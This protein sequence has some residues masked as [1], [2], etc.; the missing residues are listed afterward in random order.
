MSTIVSEQENFSLNDLSSGK[1]R[2]I[3]IPN[4]LQNSVCRTLSEK[5]L[6][7]LSETSNSLQSNIIGTSLSKHIYDK[8]GYF[9]NARKSNELIQNLFSETVS[10]LEK[11]F[12]TIELLSHKKILTATEDGNSYS[13]CAIRIHKNGDSVHLHRD[14]CNFEMPDYFV[15]KYKN[16]LSAILY[17]QTPQSGGELKIYDKIWSKDDESQRNPEFGYSFNVIEGV[18]Y[19][20]ISPVAG[21]LVL[22][23]PNYYHSIESISGTDDRISIGFFFAE[24][25]D[26][27]L[28]SWS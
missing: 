10:P 16:Q 28:Y 9:F 3:E 11:M 24:S 23:N 20:T 15:S 5:I 21:N 1:S 7:N 4:V 6:H 14:N 8:P 2:Y 25:P 12:Q 17:L 13:T 18:N 19:T 27:S 22:I 26:N